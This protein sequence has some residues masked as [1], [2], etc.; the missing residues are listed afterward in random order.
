MRK[1]EIIIPQEHLPQL[2]ELLHK[3]KVGGMSFYDIKGR[4]RTR[5][6]PITIGRGV[7]T[8]VPEFGFRTKVQ[9]LVSDALSREII[10][11]V[12]KTFGVGTSAIG[13]IFVYDVAEAYDLGTREKGDSAL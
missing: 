12:L 13:K 2:N 11:D 7:M 4:G 10:E 6:K 3:H 9:V 1:L 8:Y 5:Q